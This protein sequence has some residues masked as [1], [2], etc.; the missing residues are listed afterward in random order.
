MT[1]TSPALLEVTGLHVD[2]TNPDGSLVRAVDDV[3]YSVEAG[4]TLAV[5]GESGSG[6]TVSTRAIMGLLDPN[7]RVRG[8]IRFGDTELVGLSRRA[9][10]QLRGS[11]IALVPQDAMAA[12]DPLVPVGRQISEMF[13]IHT[14]IGHAEAVRRSIEL[15][16]LVGIPD[17]A[18]RSRDLPHTFSGGMKQRLVIAMAVAL[19]PELLIADEATSAL[20]V[21][22]QLEILDMLRR[23]KSE[24]QM[25]MIYITH[26]LLSV[27]DI[28]DHVVVM[29]AGR[30]VEAGEVRSVFARPRHPYT[31]ALLRST[32]RFEGTIDDLNPI[33][34]HPPGLDREIVGCPFASRC[35]Y[36]QPV[37]FTERPALHELPG[38]SV[39]AC[40]F[41][42][43]LQLAG[44][45]SGA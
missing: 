33:P 13:E 27:A 31:E 34:G 3:R 22:V 9:Q 15:I 40:H 10:R 18:K 21:S 38:G 26:D 30:V 29:Y 11:R 37:C 23:L 41:A 6:K 8:S 4:S 24:L 1:R 36:H 2:F 14:R 35:A 19:R 7:A 28:A 5:V 45:R 44:Q 20:D 39:S 17:A 42:E 25:S 32:P 16:E 12:L 43:E